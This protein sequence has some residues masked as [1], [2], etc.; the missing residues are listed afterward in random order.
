[1]MDPS[2]KDLLDRIRR[3]DN[4]ASGLLFER[5]RRNLFAYCRQI[6]KDEDLA[7]DALQEVFTLLMSRR[8]ALDAVKV[9]RPWLFRVARNCCLMM[10]RSQRKVVPVDEAMG[11]WDGSTPLDLAQENDVRTMVHQALG[12]MNAA[13]RE[14]IVLRIFEEMTYAEIAEI[15]EE[16]LGTIKFRIF[17]AREALIHHLGPIG[18][19]RR[20]S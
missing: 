1:M 16:P 2:D 8:A 11:V 9:L 7:K 10:L 13:Y 12:R 14:V 19:E 17:K 3:G 5:Y 15:L 6:L 18:V 20:E 4:R